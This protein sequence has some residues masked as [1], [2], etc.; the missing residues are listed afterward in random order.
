MPLSGLIIKKINE[1]KNHCK[2]I[3]DKKNIYIKN[4]EN[5]LISNDENSMKKAHIVIFSFS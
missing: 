5:F 4:V 3:L 2:V 1:K